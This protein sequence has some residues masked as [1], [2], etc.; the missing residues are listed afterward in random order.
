M[1]YIILTN[2]RMYQ[3][4]ANFFCRKPDSKYGGHCG[5]YYLCCNY[6]PLLLYHRR[7]QRYE[8]SVAVFQ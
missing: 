2:T 5:P 4:P 8:M 3:E 7:S 6:S 1:L